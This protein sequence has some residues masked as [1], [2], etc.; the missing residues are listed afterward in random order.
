MSGEEQQK[1][2]QEQVDQYITAF[3]GHIDEA[4]KRL[5]AAIAE[6]GTTDELKKFYQEIIDHLKEFKAEKEKIQAQLK[7][8]GDTGKAIEGIKALQAKH[9]EEMKKFEE[10]H[11]SKKT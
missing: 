5:E 7:T 9:V 6:E 11:P 3:V 10:K 4:I 8:D 1:P 2:T